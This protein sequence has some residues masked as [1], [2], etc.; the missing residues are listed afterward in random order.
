MC[1]MMVDNSNNNAY[2]KYLETFDI[3]VHHVNP[4]HPL[5]KGQKNRQY[6]P[7]VQVVCESHNILREYAV[8]NG[9][10][11]IF[12]VESDVM[13][14]PNT[15]NELLSHKKKVVSAMYFHGNDSNTNL[16]LQEQ[17]GW[18]MDR[19]VRRKTFEETVCFIDG[20]VKKIHAC[21]IGAAL[22]HKSILKDIEFRFTDI[23]GRI[24]RETYPD[25]YF[26]EDLA[27]DEIDAW[28]DTSIILE[29]KSQDWAIN[30]DF[31]R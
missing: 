8:E 31:H 15:L 3:K 19:K 11:F 29:H 26:Y 30:L 23:H 20:N 12:H 13:V 5:Q 4:K 28:V 6:K 2:K 10:D 16:L 22:I 7:L 9:Y 14:M 1:I 27:R 21:G 25:S 17:E 24:D 18:G